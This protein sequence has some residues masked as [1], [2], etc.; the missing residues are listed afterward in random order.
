MKSSF[1]ATARRVLRRIQ[2]DMISAFSVPGISSLGNSLWFGWVRRVLRG[3]QLS[4]QMISTT[5]DRV[6]E[7]LG[8]VSREKAMM[9]LTNQRLTDLVVGGVPWASYWF[10]DCKDITQVS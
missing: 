9:S 5:R 7:E 10:G 8:I 2:W 3:F 4:F 6:G 1:C